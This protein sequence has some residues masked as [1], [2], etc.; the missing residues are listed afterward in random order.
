MQFLRVIPGSFWLGGVPP[1][2]FFKRCAHKPMFL[3]R[4]LS[5]WRCAQMPRHHWNMASASHSV[6][7][8]WRRLQP[9]LL[10]RLH[11]VRPGMF[12][13]VWGR[14][15][16]RWPRSAVGPMA[17]NCEGPGSLRSPNA[18]AAE[19]NASKLRHS[20]RQRTRHLPFPS[21]CARQW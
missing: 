12:L 14:L 20:H 15:L 5:E 21:S 16:S 4:C 9:T 11:S 1:S 13:W 18:H 17:P 7:Q 8:V 3:L 2:F 10:H 19:R 6:T